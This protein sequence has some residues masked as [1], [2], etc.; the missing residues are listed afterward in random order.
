MSVADTEEPDAFERIRRGARV[1]RG[2]VA[3]VLVESLIFGIAALPAIGFWT[4]VAGLNVI[5]PGLVRT[6]FLAISVAPAYLIFSCGLMGLTALACR[7]LRWQV[8]EGTYS[9]KDLDPEVIRWAKHNASAHVVRVICGEL[10]RATPIWTLYL[11]GMGADIGRG[12]HVNS[13]GLYDINLITIGDHVV[14]GGKAQ[15]SAHTVEDGQL[16]T[17]PVVFERGSTI[18]TSSIV[19]PGVHVEEGGKIGALSFVTKGTRIPANT[20]YGGVPAREI[21]SR[22]TTLEVPEEGLLYKDATAGRVPDDE[23]G[24]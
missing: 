6:L 7:T 22:E 11:R 3:L 24:S 19:S 17:G 20:A 16:K 12:V 23:G 9:L 2:V 1:T 10:F 21:T 14:V 5:Q 13:A 4:W 8:P 18:G 15:M